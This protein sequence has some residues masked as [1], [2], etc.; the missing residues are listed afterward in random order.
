MKGFVTALD[1]LLVTSNTHTILYLFSSMGAA[2][3]LIAI[4][5]IAIFKYI[6]FGALF[7]LSGGKLNFW[8]FPN[9]TEDVGFFES[10]M[11]L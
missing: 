11:P 8:L 3:F 7:I 10:F 1:Y 9:L 5:G 2:G 4:M 6:L